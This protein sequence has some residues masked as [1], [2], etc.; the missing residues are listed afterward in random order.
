[1]GTSG[2]CNEWVFNSEFANNLQ[3]V[4]HSPKPRSVVEQCIKYGV[5]MDDISYLAICQRWAEDVVECND[6]NNT[7]PD[8]L[9]TPQPI[10]TSYCIY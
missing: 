4:D 8:D 2:V 1:M 6:M 7:P 10:K 9:A 5:L 3:W